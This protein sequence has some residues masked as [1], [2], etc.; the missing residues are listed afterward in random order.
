MLYEVELRPIEV[1]VKL[2]PWLLVLGME[3]LE[4]SL[5]VIHKRYSPFDCPKRKENSI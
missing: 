4:A 3:F 1:K 5:H 2:Y